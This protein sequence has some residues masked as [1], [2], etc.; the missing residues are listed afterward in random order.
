M[1]SKI[2]GIDASNIRA[3][4]GVTHLSQLLAHAGADVREAVQVVVWAGKSSLSKIESA[5]WILKESHPWLDR[6]LAWR[7]LWRQVKLPLELKRF[8]CSVLFAPGGALPWVLSLPTVTMSQNMLPFEPRERARFGL[9]WMRL[10]LALLW[11]SQSSA[12]RRASGVIFLT[13]YAQRVVSASA[14]GISGQTA[15]IPHGI[16]SRFFSQ[17][18]P[19]DPNLGRSPDAVFKLLYVSIIDMYKHHVAVAR[20][21]ASLRKRGF[22]LTVEFIGGA[23]PPALNPLL[24]AIGELDP[25]GEFLFYRG[26]IEFDELHSKYQ[27]ADGFIFASSCENLPNILI[28]AMSAGLPIA[29]SN[30]GPMPEVLRD[31]G[32]YFDPENVP[33]IESAVRTMVSSPALRFEKAEKAFLAASGY[34]WNRA[35]SQTFAF[36]EAIA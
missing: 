24:R 3:G 28:E 2:V 12:F 7:L 30:C 36:I 10:K 32:F 4:G 26:A 33:S 34:S 1:S 16:E 25:Q 20:A 18:K 22:Y 8:G 23:Y 9:S 13:E 29:C 11:F 5:P 17:P 31:A 14:W 21:I 15:L 27:A 35:A 19:Q 6:G